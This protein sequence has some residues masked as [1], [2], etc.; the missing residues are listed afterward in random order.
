MLFRSEEAFNNYRNRI[1][2]LYKA[3]DI[4][5]T[6]YQ[7]LLT[8]YD[9]IPKDFIDRQLRESQYIAKKARELLLSIC[10]NVTATSG[11]VTDFLRHTWGWDL[12]LHNLNFERYKYAGLTEIRERQHRNNIIN[13][14][15][16]KNWNKR[17]DHRH[18][19][20]DALVIACT[21][22]GYIQRLNSLSE[23]RDNS[24]K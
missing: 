3:K 10:N 7:R 11:S 9:D 23:Y 17:L 18:H 6:K 1:E 4:S 12:V 13:E 19:A 22:Q 21:Q 5:K 20:I 16:I 2:V 8:T 14:E 15:V 24:F